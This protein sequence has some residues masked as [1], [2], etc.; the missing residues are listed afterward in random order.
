MALTTGLSYPGSFKRLSIINQDKSVLKNH[1]IVERNLLSIGFQ[2]SRLLSKNLFL[3]LAL[4]A[5]I[6]ELDFS[7][8]GFKRNEEWNTFSSFVKI[9]G[10][11]PASQGFQVKAA[12]G[13]GTIFFERTQTLFS[14]AVISRDIPNW[15]LEISNARAVPAVTFELSVEKFFTPHFGLIF[16][17]IYQSSLMRPFT[18]REKL[19]QFQGGPLIEVESN[20]LETI[21]HFPTLSVGIV[22]RF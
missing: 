15:S 4:A 16:S 12:F 2:G 14:D 10:R 3:E 21:L 6:S 7:Y 19:P 13:I 17:T 5:N 18:I 20:K 9:V 22:G 11:F 8:N 1:S